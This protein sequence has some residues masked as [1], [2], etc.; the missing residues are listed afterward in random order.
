[1]SPALTA[2]LVKYALSLSRSALTAAG[3]YLVTKGY[4]T[5]DQATGSV[6]TVVAGIVTA[7][8]GQL[9]SFFKAKKD[10]KKDE[11]IKQVNLKI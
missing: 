9:F 6:D 8:I 2:I 3:A 10:V 7:G 11:A 5:P 4:L 1:M